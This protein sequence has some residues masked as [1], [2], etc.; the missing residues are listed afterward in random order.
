MLTDDQIN[1][2][3]N[4]LKNPAPTYDPNWDVTQQLLKLVALQSKQLLNLQAQLDALTES[5]DSSTEELF[6]SLRQSVNLKSTTPLNDDQVATAIQNLNQAIQSVNN[7]KK[8]IEYA[9][10]VLKFAATLLL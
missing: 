9:G 4:A 6:D 7:G 5:N 10:N 1:K 8:A 3:Q 2:F